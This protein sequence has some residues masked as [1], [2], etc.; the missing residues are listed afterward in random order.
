VLVERIITDREASEMG[1]TVGGSLVIERLIK[2]NGR[3]EW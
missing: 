3:A 2:T 1:K